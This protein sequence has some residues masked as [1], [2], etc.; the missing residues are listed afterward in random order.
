M[1]SEKNVPRWLGATFLFVI[2]VS[3]AS[4]LLLSSATGTGTISEMLA[5][6]SRNIP[7]VRI[8]VLLEMLNSTGII[9][10]AS[11]LYIVLS[12]QDKILALI[13]LGWWL[14]EA[15]ILGF[16]STA[17]FALIRLGQ[18]FVQVGSPLNSFY[19][20][21]GDFLYY[22]IY[23]HGYGGIHMWFYCIGGL[24]WYSLFYRSRYIPRAISLFGIV[25]VSL[26]F[27]AVVL[28]FLGLG[29]PLWISIPLLPFELTIAFWLLF[30]G[31]KEGPETDLAVHALRSAG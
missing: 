4:G 20:V 27:I 28:H 16:T 1:I 24:V 9:V 26:A 2:F 12:R 23:K 21:L 3:L 14:G 8:S 17:V 25:A 5:N 13:A 15:L 6:V 18:D 10:L 31:I 7:L 19:Q 29:A 30:R 22:G 11:L